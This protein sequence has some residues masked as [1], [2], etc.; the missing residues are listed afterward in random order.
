[1]DTFPPAVPANVK[2]IVGTR[3][4]E[5]SWSRDTESD[6]AGYRVFRSAEGGPFTLVADKLTSPSYSD[7]AV[8]SGARYRYAV[9]AFD[10]NQ[11]ESARSNPIDVVVP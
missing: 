10:Q 2:A 8:K 6:L 3:S 11:N 7:R 5:V 9:S 1:V 4:V